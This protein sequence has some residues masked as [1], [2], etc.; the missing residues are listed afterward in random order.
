VNGIF[1]AKGPGIVKGEELRVPIKLT[2]VVPTI[3]HLLG[4]PTPKDCEGKILEEVLE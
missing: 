2:D 1:I 3:S 4:M